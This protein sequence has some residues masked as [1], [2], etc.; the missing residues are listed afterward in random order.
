MYKNTGAERKSEGVKL[1]EDQLVIR[2]LMSEMSA[3][4]QTRV[5]GT[6]LKL[7]SGINRP[8]SCSAGRRLWA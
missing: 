1:S 2:L 6:K 3:L 4:A 7:S 5:E 8:L